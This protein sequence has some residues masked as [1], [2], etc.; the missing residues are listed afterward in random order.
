MASG[1][2]TTSD[3]RMLRALAEEMIKIATRIEKTQE[4][5]YPSA[6]RKGKSG[7]TAADKSRLVAGRNKRI[8]S[9]PYP[10]TGKN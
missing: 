3:V 7:L 4:G 1:I 9:S 10:N 8:I 5:V 2:A 6:A